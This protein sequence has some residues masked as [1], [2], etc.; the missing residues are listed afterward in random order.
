MFGGCEL[1]CVCVLFVM[2]LCKLLCGMVCWLD[3]LVDGGWWRVL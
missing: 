3:E 1:I 2:L